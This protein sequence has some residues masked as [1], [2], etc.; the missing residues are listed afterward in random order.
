MNRRLMSAVLLII[1]LAVCIA[2]VVVPL[3]C[4]AVLSQCVQTIMRQAVENDLPQTELAIAEFERLL[5]A[6]RPLYLLFMHRDYYTALCSFAATFREYNNPETI[7]DLLAE[8]ERTL[9]CLNT[10]RLVAAAVV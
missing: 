5:N 3:R 10:I 9:D 7:A 4:I 6:Q 1:S 2:S 8:A